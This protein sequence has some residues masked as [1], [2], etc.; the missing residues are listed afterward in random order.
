[1]YAT[2]DQGSPSDDLLEL[3]FVNLKHEHELDHRIVQLY[4]FQ[5]MLEAVETLG[6]F[7]HLSDWDIYFEIVTI[8]ETTMFYYDD[9]FIV[10]DDSPKSMALTHVDD[11]DY[12]SYLLTVVDDNDIIHQIPAYEIISIQAFR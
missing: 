6:D 9:F 8:N 12:E 1:M 2:L 3:T 4:Q 10:K 7:E 11:K 5:L